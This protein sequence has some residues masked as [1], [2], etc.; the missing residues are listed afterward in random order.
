MKELLKLLKMDQF[1]VINAYIH[2]GGR[3]GYGPPDK[4][5]M[6]LERETGED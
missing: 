4:L 1:K 2:D 3:M 5:Q 6:T